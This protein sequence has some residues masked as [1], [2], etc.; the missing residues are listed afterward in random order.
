MSE[1]LWEAIANDCEAP[2]QFGKLMVPIIQQTEGY[3]KHNTISEIL[4][5]LKFI[6]RCLAISRV[7][8]L[9]RARERDFNLAEIHSVDIYIVSV[10]LY[11]R[12]SFRSDLPLKM[13]LKIFERVMKSIQVADD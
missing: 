13:Q 6:K 5:M 3:E 8:P 2:I 4:D 1:I 7:H 11:S 10:V 12:W 9:F